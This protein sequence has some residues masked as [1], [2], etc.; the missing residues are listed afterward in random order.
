MKKGKPM[1]EY[2]IQTV[3]DTKTGLIIMQN[4]VEQENDANQLISAIDYIQ[5]TYGKTPKYILADNG[6]YKIESIEYTFYNGITPIIPD[7]SESMNNNGRNADNPFAKNNMPFDPINKHFTCPNM[8]KLKPTGTKMINGILNDIYMTEKCPECPYKK[9]CAKTQKYRKLFEPT[10]P[11][12][13]D[14]K[15]IFQSPLG[16]K[17]YKLRAVYNEGNFANLKS[18]QEFTKSRRI[19]RKKVEIGLKLEA[20]VINIKKNNPTPKPNTNITKS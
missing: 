2:L 19:G 5:H 3:T 10:S 6:Y 8:Q 17:L 15:L 18:H 13:I 20:I 16:K 14:E 1:F 11:A 7:R 4:V 12:L 9:E